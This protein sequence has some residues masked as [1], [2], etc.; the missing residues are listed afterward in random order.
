MLDDV[1]SNFCQAVLLGLARAAFGTLVLRA[2]ATWKAEV[3]VL[4]PPLA[5]VPLESSTSS[6]AAQLVALR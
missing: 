1:A 2:R 4:F 3:A 5:L 6:P